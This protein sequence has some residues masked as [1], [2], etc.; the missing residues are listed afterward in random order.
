M[1]KRFKLFINTDFQEN[2]KNQQ[3]V[4]SDLK[5]VEEFEYLL[6]EL[7]NIDDNDFLWLRKFIDSLTELPGKYQYNYFIEEYWS[8][9]KRLFDLSDEIYGTQNF[10]R[11]INYFS[12]LVYLDFIFIKFPYFFQNNLN[13]FNEIKY[14]HNLERFKK[15]YVQKLLIYEQ[16][17]FNNEKNNSIFEIKKAII[18]TLK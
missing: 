14:H 4:D 8:V 1:E 10:H 15:V 2:I 12:L 11:K 13:L 16:Y 18:S 7:L 3:K 5:Q 17:D 9:F 6:N